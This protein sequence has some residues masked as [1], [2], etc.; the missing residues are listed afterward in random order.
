[1]M[2]RNKDAA[3]VDPSVLDRVGRIVAE[4]DASDFVLEDPPADLWDSIAAAVASDEHQRHTA[5]KEP[6]SRDPGTGA[7][8]E[9]WIDGNDVMVEVG[10]GWSEFAHDNGAPG[11]TALAPDRTLWTYFDKAEVRELWR[12]LVDRIRATRKQARVPL[13][14]DA[15]HA[16]RW[17]EM[18]VTPETDGRVHFRCV[19]VFEETREPVGLLDLQTPRNQDAEPVPVCSWCGRGQSGSAWLDIEELVHVDRLL[20]QQSMP[21]ISFGICHSCR[22]DM[23]AELLLSAGVTDGD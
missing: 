21:P 8:V 9:Y 6:P 23:S 13:R 14:C 19:L 12:L 18:V 22:H 7:V 5:A 16:R 11:L 17:F 20:E 15:P 10:G 2:E 4:I 3:D 1:M